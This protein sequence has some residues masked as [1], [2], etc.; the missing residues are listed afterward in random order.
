[1]R[2]GETVTFGGGGG[3]D[4]AAALRGRPGAVAAL[5]AGGAARVLPLWRGKPLIA[6]AARARLGWLPPDHAALSAAREPPLFLGLAGGAPHFAADISAWE[7]AG[8]DAAATAAFFDA[9]EQEHPALPPDHRFAELRGAMARLAPLEAELAATAR[10]LAEWHRTHGYC[11]RC[12]AHS[13][14]A[15]GGWQR[16]CTACGAH[17]FPRTDPVVIML[18]TRG[19]SL[20]VGRSHGWPA[21]MYSLLAGFVE[22]GETI[23][24]AVRREVAEEAG[25]RVGP[26]RYLASQPWPFPASLMLGC[27]GEALDDAITIDRTEIEDARWITREAMVEV[28]LDRH[29]DVKP[30][31]RGAIARFLI[32]AWL[33]DRIA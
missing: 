31:R 15:E 2:D 30:A 3:L 6:G 13:E 4:R 9:T 10:G 14:P 11:A 22:P 21:G 28:M 12:G 7:P 19:N 5:L 29:P 25:V 8:V 23:E 32:E 16:R 26:V 1:M 24:A 27:H 18:V 20:L 33:A 17:H